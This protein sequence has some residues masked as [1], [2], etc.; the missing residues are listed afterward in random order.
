M[1][2]CP[3]CKKELTREGNALRCESNHS[4][5]YA[6]SGY[7][8]LL[9]PGKKKN[10]KAG[11]SKEMIRARTSFFECGAYEKI[12]DTLTELVLSL[13]GK[14]V[15]DA[16]CGEGY[17]SLGIAKT[18]TGSTVLGFDMSKF[19]CE[20]GA[21]AA[22][23][24]GLENVFFSVANIFDLPLQDNY[25]DIVVSLFAPV[26]SEEFSRILKNGGYL[27]V[28][29][30]GINHLD[31]LKSVLYDSV[32]QNEEKF[33]EF[34]SFSLNEIKSLKYRTVIEGNEVIEALFT[35][36]PYYHRTSQ[37]DKEKLKSVNVL[38]TTVEVNFL[39]YQNKKS[40]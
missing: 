13:G 3:I 17:Y 9:N 12:K 10:A 14:T 32:Y 6:K 19:G 1:F 39:I 5:D 4:F 15:V 34:D 26:A 22:R 36:T 7:I 38:E 2:L 25:C 37:A 11:D 30:A 29:S 28:A 21:K 40:N 20:H 27:V 33:L 31:G 35:M 8:N 23:A 16:G 18:N 24:K